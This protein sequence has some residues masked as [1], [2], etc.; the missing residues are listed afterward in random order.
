MFV[1]SICLSLADTKSETLILDKTIPLYI[2]E[3]HR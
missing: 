3:R 2:P 1:W